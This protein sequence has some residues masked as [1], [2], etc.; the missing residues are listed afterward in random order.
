M[1]AEGL[2]RGWQEAVISVRDLD[3]WIETAEVALGWG[4]MHRGPLGSDQ[5][6]AWGLPNTTAGDEAL[7]RCGDEPQGFVRFAALRNVAQQ[8]VRAGCMSWDTGGVFSLMVRSRD[9][10][11]VARAVLDRGWTTVTEP[12]TFDYNGQMLTN[13]IL[14]GPDGVCFGVY[15]RVKPLLPGWSHIKRISQPFN[16]MQ[17]VR[18]RDVTRDFHRDVLGF[19]AYVDDDTRPAT[20]QP[21]NFGI[22]RNITTQIVTRAAI[23][24]PQA[25]QGVA[26]R[27]NGRVELIQ[28]DGL[29]GQ[30]MASRAVMPN[31]GIMILRWPTPDAS[32]LAAVLTGRG[33]TLYRAPASVTIAPYGTVT[34]FAVR[35]PDG[36]IYEFFTAPR[37]GTSSQ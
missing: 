13:V 17:M 3:R 23:M 22:P 36:V 35:T 32:A 5:I 11:G 33:A 8:R 9:A 24:H 29:E 4:L 12:A 31:L 6:A 21:S 1:T 19:G 15:E 28:W 10:A 27:S 2:E 25:Q 16:A 7:F 30:D 20:P 18:S 14:R 26:E 34:V 37:S